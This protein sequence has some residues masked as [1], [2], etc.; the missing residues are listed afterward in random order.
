MST[1]SFLFTAL[2]FQA[3]IAFAKFNDCLTDMSQVKEL[4]LALAG[5]VMCVTSYLIYS[6]LIN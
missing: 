6:I 4:Y 3:G 2:F 1:E 5:L